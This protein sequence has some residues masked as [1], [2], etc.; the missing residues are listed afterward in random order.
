MKIFRFMSYDEFEKYLKGEILE[1]NTVHKGQTNSEGFCFFSLDDYEPEQAVHFLSGIA[2]LEVCAVFETDRK[3]KQT[4]GRYAKCFP[5]TDN[6]EEDIQKILTGQLEM[7]WAT[8]YCRNTYSRKNF[9]LQKYSI[10][11]YKQWKPTEEQ[12]PFKWEVLEDET[13]K[14][15]KTENGKR[16]TAVR[17]KQKKINAVTED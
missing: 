13:I 8:E 11:I 15:T 5:V 9:K 3:L 4:K 17:G 14:G 6:F 16:N 7:F 10:D 1:N 12:T 2:T